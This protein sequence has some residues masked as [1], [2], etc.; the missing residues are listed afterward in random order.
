MIYMGLTAHYLHFTT[1]F[2]FHKVMHKY[3][4][5]STSIENIAKAGEIAVCWLLY[6]LWIIIC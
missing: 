3:F 4:D 5:L 6:P 1:C 2:L